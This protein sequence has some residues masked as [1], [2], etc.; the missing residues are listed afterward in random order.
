MDR[1]LEQFVIEAKEYLE[2]AGRLVIDLEENGGPGG[3]LNEL[4]RLLHTLKGN[5]GLFN[6]SYL[7]NVFHAAEDVLNEIRGARAKWSPAITDLLLEVVD[8]ASGILG[9]IESDGAIEEKAAAK[10]EEL[11]IKLRAQVQQGDQAWKP[12]RPQIRSISVNQL[13]V[14]EDIVARIKD[15]LEKEIP[16]SFVTYV[17]HED[18]FYRGDD[19]F[20]LVRQ[21]PGLLWGKCY[22]RNAIKDVSTFDL[23]KCSMC[24]QF[25]T[26]STPDQ[27]YRYFEYVWDQIDCSTVDPCDQVRP[28]ESP[29]GKIFYPNEDI[30]QLLIEQKEVL[31][32]ICKKNDES[33]RNTFMSVVSVLENLMLPLSDPDMAAKLAVIKT[34][35][36]REGSSLLIELIDNVLSMQR[37]VREI[38]ETKIQSPALGELSQ[39]VTSVVAPSSDRQRNSIKV[40]RVEEGKI[41]RLVNLVGELIVAKN[42]LLYIVQRINA[43]SCD[44]LSLT[45]EIKNQYFV[46]NRIAEEMHDAVMRIKMVPVS[47]VFEKV[48]RLVRDIAG[49]LKKKVKL[50]MEGEDTEA[51][52]NIIEALSEPLVHLI[53]NSV[54]HGIEPPSERVRRGKPGTGTL[55]LR[56]KHQSDRL[57]IE[58]EDDGKGIDP[59]AVKTKAYEQGMI[60]EKELKELTDEEAINLV[61]LPGF[62]TSDGASEFSGRG[63]G[64][65]S[66]K[67]AV[68]KLHGQVKLWSAPGKG[69]TVTLSLPLSM[70]VSNILVVQCAG[71]CYGVPME[72]I[73]ETV[74]VRRSDIQGFKGNMMT[75]LRGHTVPIIFLNDI[76]GNH[77]SNVMYEDEEY[78]T[79]V[80]KFEEKMAAVVVDRFCGVTQVIVK[81]LGGPLGNIDMLAGTTI[82]GDGSVMLV[83]NPKEI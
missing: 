81:P 45:K 34:K 54:D 31:N 51:D 55:V 53:R 74:K 18:C 32:F 4:F 48:P 70:A 35:D 52:K 60:D 12:M 7:T 11:T 16:V 39:R 66:V 3:E 28:R 27:L 82:M 68:Q 65:D 13:H 57:V 23:F 49:K 8:L 9:T 62:S 41:D 64:M 19:P 17:P 77:S 56:A 83:L 75:L 61:F 42:S 2:K 30:V 47:N 80:L 40:V 15:F 44:F 46:V 6:L 72:A 78:A 38:P 43:D 67:T 33:T 37:L 22:L 5:S 10:V 79:M 63:V 29:D 50:V 73:V 24:F 21:T 59:G 69:T 76:I 1:L 14:P 25:L 26:L 58:L 36:T 71:A 20:F